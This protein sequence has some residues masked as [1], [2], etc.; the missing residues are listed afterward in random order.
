VPNVDNNMHDTNVASFFH[1]KGRL[2]P[3]YTRPT[4][5][6]L[7]MQLHKIPCMAPIDRYC[8]R[9]MYTDDYMQDSKQ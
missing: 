8:S 9:K 5:F 6:K 7:V 1:P 4:S 2:I 3:K